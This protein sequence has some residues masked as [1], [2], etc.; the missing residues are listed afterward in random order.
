VVFKIDPQGQET[1][2]H[3]FTGGLDGAFPDANLIRDTAGNLYGTA[4]GGG[5]ENKGVV[6]EI[7]PAGNERVL[8]DFNGEDGASPLGSLLLFNGALYGT[9]AQGG[10]GFGVV[11]KISLR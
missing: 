2:L 11:F 3:E 10:R 7:D 1:I 8:H 4:Y 9:T 5:R 6:F